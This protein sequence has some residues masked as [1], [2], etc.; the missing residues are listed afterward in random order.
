MLNMIDAGRIENV[1]APKI[2]ISYWGLPADATLRDVALVVRA[3]EADHRLV[4]HNLSD[5]YHVK[6][7]KKPWEVF[8]INQDLPFQLPE[9]QANAAGMTY[10]EYVKREQQMAA[11]KK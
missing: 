4:N 3:D 1:P 5:L 7:L 6:E 11:A 9:E 10:A 8:P 2:A